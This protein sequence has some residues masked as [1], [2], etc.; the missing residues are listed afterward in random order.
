MNKKIK[1]EKSATEKVINNDP[2]NPAELIKEKS[3]A[4][5]KAVTN[6]DFLLKAKKSLKKSIPPALSFVFSFLCSSASP[7]LGCMPFGIAAVCSAGRLW[8]ATGALLGMFA[9]SIKMRPVGLIYSGTSAAIFFMRMFMGTLGIVKTG[10]K[11]HYISKDQNGKMAFSFPSESIY[12]K[13]DRAFSSSSGCNAAVSLCAALA[14]GI[15]GIIIG[16]NL[17][18]DVFS[19]TLGIVL[20]PVFTLAYSSIGNEGVSPILYKTGI[21]AVVYAVSTALAGIEIGGM[22]ISVILAFVFTLWSAW[23]FGVTDGV[24]FGFF[25]GI[26]LEPSLSAMYAVAGAVLGAL[27]GF[28]LGVGC[29]TAAALAISW[30]LYSNGLPSISEVVPEIILSTAIFYPA[31]YFKVLPSE[32]SFSNE[33]VNYINSKNKLSYSTSD[34]LKKIS[35]AMTHLSGIFSGLSKRLRIPDNTETLAICTDSFSSSCSLCEKKNICHHRENF[36]NV[37]VI[38]RVALDLKDAGK[39]SVASFPETM[40]RGCPSI[41]IIVEKIN[42]EYSKLFES[43]ARSDKTSVSAGDYAMMARLIRETV[44]VAD[45]ENSKNEKLS[46]LLENIFSKNKIRYEGLGVYGFERPRI[47]VR[48]FD[49]RDLTYGSKDIREMAESALKISLNDPEMSIDYDKLNMFMDCR[50]R[51]SLTYGQYSERAHK[52]EANGDTVTCFKDSNETFYMLLCDGMGSGREAALT[53]R[54]SAVFLE[55]M[56]GAG[57]PVE[58]AFTMLNDF[59]RER[60]I[61]CSSSVDLLKIDPFSCEA[62]FIKSG[63]ASSFVLRE[64]KLFCISSDTPPVGI[65]KKAVAKKTSFLLKNGDCIVMLSDGAVPD[66]EEGTTWLYDTLASTSFDEKSDLSLSAQ[67]TVKEAVKRRNQADDC[68]VSIVYVKEL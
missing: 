33:K 1:I 32:L 12:Q 29:C 17:W 5:F 47:F 60:R 34:R 14:I 25:A 18:Y 40:A 66:D 42:G 38:K 26:A 15:F 11:T 49:V 44:T 3:E 53:S 35:E 8:E 9:A 63:A 64:N 65:L 55:K 43:T 45:E 2:K 54:V 19:A 62:S 6:E 20:I 28:S 31:A 50:K 41:D 24:M 48:G 61:E 52:C 67:K 4:V 36:K 23:C 22:D 10:Y 37:S 59:T 21:G 51:I 56:I 46:K 30:A 39:V 27:S 16:G 68:T 13:F 7:A 58:I 57:C